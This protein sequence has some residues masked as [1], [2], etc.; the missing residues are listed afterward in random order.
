MKHK[1]CL[2]CAILALILVLS[3]CTPCASAAN[4]SVSVDGFPISY[5]PADG[6]PFAGW[7]GS[8]MIP[9]KKTMDAYGAYI[10]RDTVTGAYVVQLGT[11]EVLLTPGSSAIIVNGTP[12]Q[13]PDAP[14]VYGG[15]LY[16]PAEELVRG[17]GGYCTRQNGTLAIM[18]QSADSRLVRIETARTSESWSALHNRYLEGNQLRHAGSY[19]AAA[20]KYEASIPGFSGDEAN[21]GMIFQYLGECYARTGA[22]DAAAAAYARSAYYFSAAGR[23]FNASVSRSCASSLRPEMSLYL[24]TTDPSLSRET[25]HGVNYE[26]AC[27]TVLGYAGK[28]FLVNDPYAASSAK[29]AG[30][31]LI[32]YRWGV[33]SLEQKLDPVPDNIVV[34]LAV[35][36]HE[37][38][39][40]V[41]DSDIIAFAQRLHTCGKKV[42]VRYANEMN[43]PSVPWYRNQPDYPKNYK[44]EYIRFAKLMRTYAPEVPLIW[45]PN[46]FPPETVFSFYPGDAYVDYVG[47]SS[48]IAR[49]HYTENE[50]KAGYDAL[51]TGYRL[52]RWSRQI[53]FLYNRFGYK[54][55]IIISEGAASLVDQATGANAVPLAAQQIRDFYT[56]LTI[57]YPNL[58]YAV[59]FNINTNNAEY[60][61]TDAASTLA[62]YNGAVSDARYLSDATAAAAHCYVPLDTFGTMQSVPS[63]PQQLCAYVNYGD[64]SRVAS[65]RYE[66]NGH[67]AGSATEPPYLINCDFSGYFGTVKIRASVLDASGSVLD[68]KIFPLTVGGMSDVDSSAYYAQPVRWAVENKVSSGTTAHT[69]S[70]DA[71]CTRGQA[72]T[73]LWRAAGCPQPSSAAT[74]F[75]DVHSNDYYSSA[76]LW[77]AERGI[78][79]G[80]SSST[81]SPNLTC[82]RGQCVTFLYRA[83]GSPS[84]GSRSVPFVDVPASEYYRVPVIWATENGITSGTTATTF[85][86]LQLCTRG[87]IV[88]FLYRAR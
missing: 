50:Q 77:A 80:T 69:F 19:A 36:P 8:V 32:Y 34:E 43:E 28:S 38:L 84:V 78:T 40:N 35:E 60:M 22:Y 57:R 5:T 4:V 70:P 79:N 33:S 14:L 66:I 46:F 72:V 21:L 58:K 18:T 62:A 11:R 73:F 31:W 74:P 1:A 53:D 88:T 75:T 64:N 76:V 45:S 20:A 83:A 51:G 12:V 87:Q 27:G 59:Y 25:N 44:A 67:V 7:N 23:S 17:L 30:M 16:A 48:Y 81:F 86:P 6:T 63:A 85:S 13:A 47:I 41:K 42:M 15:R 61:M 56:Y 26:P 37:G 39:E 65:V 24:K 49:Y 55:P 52:Q 10:N 3:V 71:P 54:K 9:V 68:S 29:Q 2:S 82:T